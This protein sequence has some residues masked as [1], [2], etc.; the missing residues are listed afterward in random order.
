MANNR[1]R[2]P[3]RLQ[4]AIKRFVQR[5]LAA[6]RNVRKV[7]GISKDGRVFGS[8][9]SKL[10]ECTVL[11]RETK[12]FFMRDDA[13][14][15]ETGEGES[16]QLRALAGSKTASAQAAAEL[17]NYLIC[18]QTG[19]DDGVQQFPLPPSIVTS[20]VNRTA[21]KAALPQVVSYFRRPIFDEEFR[22]LGPG[23]HEGIKTLI[24]GHVID[25]PY[26]GEAPSLSRPILE[27]LP[28]LSRELLRN[29]VFRDAADT[30]NAIAFL[31]TGLLINHFIDTGKPPALLDGNQP[32]VGKTLLVI[33]TGI[34]L[35]G[36]PPKLNRYRANDAEL[37]KEVTSTAR[38]SDQS[39]LLIDNA[40]T[41][42][43]GGEIDSP[44]LESTSVAPTF[45]SRILGVSENFSR[46]NDYLW[47]IT[48]NSAKASKDLVSRML[49]IRFFFEGDP[50]HRSVDEAKLL[51]F[52]REKRVEILAELA[53]M[54]DRWNRL[55][56]PAGTANHRLA[57]WANIIGGILVANG[58]PEVLTNLDAA[59]SDVDANYDRL[60][61]IAEAVLRDPNGPWLRIE[62]DTRQGPF[63]KARSAANWVTYF[64]A[65]EIE[66]KRFQ[67]TAS[68][69]GKTTIVGSFL[70][71]LIGSRVVVEQGGEEVEVELVS[72]QGRSNHKNYVLLVRSKAATTARSV[73]TA[74]LPPPLPRKNPSRPHHAHRP[75]S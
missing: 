4:R 58:F 52:A 15:Y 45:T 50:K 41:K 2:R 49:P 25:P 54:V 66:Q 57:N 40:K 8:Y 32:G 3:S 53:A 36:A 70:T 72:Q 24:H 13:I 55:G 75:V 28:P 12:R 19:T 38:T 35:D 61:A 30:A 5:P 65:A 33:V 47:A 7:T 67:A 20:L 60:A 39:V 56:R 27:R 64:N 44:F 14:W 11:L 9:D 31:L 68:E 43:G 26:L 17:A 29:F 1:E 59:A 71:P 48:A 18:E 37:E 21:T 73:R 74:A 42:A 51:A 34:L 6:A 22:L 46:P 62:G 10:E 69:R 63:V 23:Y 16:A